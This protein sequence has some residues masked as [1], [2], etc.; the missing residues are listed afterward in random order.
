MLV[1]IAVQVKRPYLERTEEFT[2]LPTPLPLFSTACVCRPLG[3]TQRSTFRLALKEL[4][5]VGTPVE[6]A[7]ARGP[8]GRCGAASETAGSGTAM[9]ASHCAGV[10]GA[11]QSSAMNCPVGVEQRI[12]GGGDGGDQREIA[13]HAFVIEEVEELVLDDVAAHAGAELVARFGGLMV[14]NGIPRVEVLVAEEPVR[15][16]RED[17]SMP[18]RVTVL[19][20]PPIARPNSAE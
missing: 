15:R 16:C 10:A 20:T 4:R 17:R 9:A 6:F 7:E 5:S 8:A 1:G 12:A 19:T 2:L 18:L 13:P 11:P 3:E 14:A